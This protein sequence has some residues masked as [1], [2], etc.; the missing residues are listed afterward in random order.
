MPQVNSLSSLFGEPLEELE[1]KPLQQGSECRMWAD[2]KD[3]HFFHD[4][5]NL[6]FMLM[7]LSPPRIYECTHQSERILEKTKGKKIE[8]Y[9]MMSMHI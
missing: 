4:S 3:L 9:I 1:P 8:I 7:I 2:V 6:I 5:L